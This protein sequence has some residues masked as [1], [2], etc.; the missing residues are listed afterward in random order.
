METETYKFDEDSFHQ[1]GSFF[2]IHLTWGTDWSKRNGLDSVSKP[3][4]W[5]RERWNVKFILGEG[6]VTA[7]KHIKVWHETVLWNSI[8]NWDSLELSSK[9]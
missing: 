4:G 2:S 6:E 8:L 7:S 1:S 3:L 5:S 9:G